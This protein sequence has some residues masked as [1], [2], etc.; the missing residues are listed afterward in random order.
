MVLYFLFCGR[1][2]IMALNPSVSMSEIS[3]YSAEKAHS[4]GKMEGTSG[5]IKGNHKIG[6]IE[7]FESMSKLTASKTTSN[8]DLNDRLFR[9]SKE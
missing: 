8:L 3:S 4:E 7:K 9:S 1:F 6:D 2:D 5:M